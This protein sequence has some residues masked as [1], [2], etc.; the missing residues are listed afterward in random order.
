MKSSHRSFLT[1]T[2]HSVI[3]R[4]FTSTYSNYCILPCNSCLLAKLN[5]SHPILSRCLAISHTFLLLSQK[6]FVAANF[7][8]LY[9]QFSLCYFFYWSPH[10]WEQISKKTISCKCQEI[11]LLPSWWPCFCY[12]ENRIN[13]DIFVPQTNFSLPLLTSPIQDY[14]NILVLS[15]SKVEMIK[16]EMITVFC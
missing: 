1:K 13:Q 8:F 12:E 4:E 14:R 10:Y 5:F 2:E 11:L 6:G 9:F 3:T 16:M 15:S 7:P